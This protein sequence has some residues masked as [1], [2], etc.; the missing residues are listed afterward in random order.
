M[1]NA[2]YR[3][4]CNS[5]LQTLTESACDSFESHLGITPVADIS[6]RRQNII[7]AI[8]NRF[9]FNDAALAAK[10][11]DLA[12]GAPMRFEI[13]S[14]KLTLRLWREGDE[15]NGSFLAY[16]I[17]KVLKPIIPQN[18]EVITEARASVDYGYFLSMTQ[19]VAIN[20]TTPSVFYD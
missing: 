8:N 19:A 3:F 9:V 12:N 6:A 2:I 4:F 1:Q 14:Q 7:A 15:A 11:E 5:N 20:S 18:I 13:D 17:A 10:I 16:D